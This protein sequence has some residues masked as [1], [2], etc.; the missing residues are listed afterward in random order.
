MTRD[1]YRAKDDHD[2]LVILAERTENIEKC[3]DDVKAGRLPTCAV[4]TEEVRSIWRSLNRLWAIVIGVPSIA[5][6]LVGIF[7]GLHKR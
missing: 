1:E 6:A 7:I 3:M 5:G 4:H 2:L